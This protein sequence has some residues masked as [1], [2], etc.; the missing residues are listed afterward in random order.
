M[1]KY[2]L[3]S[4]PRASSY[5]Q[6]ITAGQARFTIQLAPPLQVG[7]RCLVAQ[8]DPSPSV[9]PVVMSVVSVN[10]PAQMA[11]L[12]VSERYNR[13]A[14]LNALNGE[15]HQIGPR[16]RLLRERSAAEQE[17]NHSP[18]ELLRLT[19]A[20]WEAITGS[21]GGSRLEEQALLKH[22]HSYISARG[23]YFDQET[24]YNYHICL[25]TRP[26]VI[27]AGLSGTGKSKLTQLYAEALGVPRER[28][29]RLAVRPNWNDDRYLLGYFNPIS[30]SYITEPALDFLLDASKNEQDLYCCCLDE[31]NLAHVEYYFSQF[32]SALEEERPADRRIAL[33]S[34]RLEEELK[35]QGQPL[36]VPAE[37]SLPPNL[38]FTGTI[39][40]DETTQ[41]ISDKV[42]DRANTIEFFSIDLD[43]IPQPTVP[44]DPVP[45]SALTWQ[46][47]KAQQPDTRYR[48]LLRTINAML[49][50]VELGLGYRVVREIEL[51]L[52]NSAGLLEPEVALD[53]QIKQRILPR[54][55]GTEVIEGVLDELLA[56]TRT[57][58]LPRSYQ[59]LEE[60]KNRLKRDGYTSFWR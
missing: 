43:K 9:L 57:Q 7:D 46:S 60:M 18:I 51:Y 4:L 21:M 14:D 32:L 56:L 55:R 11:T 16:S 17:L 52:A 40:V 24:L 44:P 15:V 20:D 27:L 59:R 48:E 23:Y 10:S 29:L 42:I 36:T 47:Y 1:S 19:K 2:F 8:Q 49:N 53:L 54:V 25:K 35:R 22:I 33:V 31:M 13:P 28:Y 30:G 38:L 58:Q 37:L 26:F 50:K 5:L 3:L 34:R 12:E 41:P 39:N 6:T 45:I